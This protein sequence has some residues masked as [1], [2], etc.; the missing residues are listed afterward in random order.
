M[1]DLSHFLIIVITF[2]QKI[3]IIFFFQN[4]FMMQS[5]GTTVALCLLLLYVKIDVNNANEPNTKNLVLPTGEYGRGVINSHQNINFTA[6]S[7]NEIENS[8]E[9]NICNTEECVKLSV[10]MLSSLDRSVNPCENFYDF[11]CGN[12]IRNTIIPKDKSIIMSFTQVQD[13]VE[14]QLRRILTEAPRQNESK[15]F[16]LAKT[17]TSACLN[18]TALNEMGTTNA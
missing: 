14:E 2:D 4:G 15:P 9:S 18:E 13:K 6:D 17:F 1:N 8:S 12:F 11:A 7:I 3:L 5:I 16:K 10:A